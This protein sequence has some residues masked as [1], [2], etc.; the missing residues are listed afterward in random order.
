MHS[1][2]LTRDVLPFT[3]LGADEAIDYT[4]QRF[5]EVLK[6]RAVD[7]VIDPIGSAHSLLVPHRPRL[8]QLQPGLLRVS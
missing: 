2:G 5:E 3:Q 8:R 7:A 1:L 6:G 4:Q